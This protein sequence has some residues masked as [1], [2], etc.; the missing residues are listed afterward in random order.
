MLEDSFYSF[1]DNLKAI[2][3]LKKSEYHKTRS[4]IRRNIVEVLSSGM[5][6]ETGNRRHLMNAEEIRTELS[7]QYEM[8]IKKPSL[9]HH[10]KICEE[11]KLI[12][13]VA[14]PTPGR[15]KKFRAYYGRTAKIYLVDEPMEKDHDQLS[16]L[17]PD[18]ILHEGLVN[19]I[20]IMNKDVTDEQLTSVFNSI[21]QINIKNSEYF[22]NWI[23]QN[24]TQIS[25]SNISIRNIFILLEFLKILDSEALK[26]IQELL[27]LINYR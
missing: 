1:W 15:G 25:K 27:K 22:K 7:E 20:K 16:I 3:F 21:L 9:Y 17:H 18:S 14:V 2:Q 10:L 26:G 12:Q 6:D 24:D 23:E 19:F 4:E 5:V 8:E 13:A 11:I